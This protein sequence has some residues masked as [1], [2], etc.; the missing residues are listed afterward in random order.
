LLKEAALKDIAPPTFHVRGYT[1][2]E[3][4]L[5]SCFLQLAAE[6]VDYIIAV[7]ADKVDLSV[8]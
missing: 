7:C 5:V 1:V 2:A 3:A 8:A 4:F 6:N